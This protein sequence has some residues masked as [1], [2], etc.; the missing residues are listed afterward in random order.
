VNLKDQGLAPRLTG[1]QEHGVLAVLNVEE[2]H[3]PGPIVRVGDVL[4]EWL[5]HRMKLGHVMKRPVPV[6]VQ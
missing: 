2:E 4:V 3:K 1:Q 5:S 6:L